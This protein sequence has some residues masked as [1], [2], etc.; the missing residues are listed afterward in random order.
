MN[1]R[2]RVLLVCTGNAARSQMAEALVR[3]LSNGT[4]DVHS[5]GTH[6]KEAVHPMA[7][8]VMREDFGID[9]SGQSP[10]SI[11]RYVGQ[12]FDYVIT[13]CDDAAETCPVFPGA[14][15]TIHWGF[16]DPAAVE[17]SPEDQRHAF[18]KVGSELAGRIRLWLALPKV[19]DR[20]TT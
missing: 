1:S 4:I 14:P 18:E 20:A 12:D 10:K 19:S 17:T 5:A 2:L 16:S 3:S 7:T 15:E 13:L 6:P 8:S 11:D 9:L